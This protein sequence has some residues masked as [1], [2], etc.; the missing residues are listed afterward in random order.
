[1]IGWL[2]LCPR[3]TSVLLLLSSISGSGVRWRQEWTVMMDNVSCW[4]RLFCYHEEP[5]HF[6]DVF[7]RHSKIILK[8]MAGKYKYRIS[9]KYTVRNQS[10]AVQFQK[11]NC[12]TE[13]DSL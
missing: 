4:N 12:Y 6:T 3:I 2:L 11:L 13:K 5:R 1:M 10:K 9:L 8:N 7:N